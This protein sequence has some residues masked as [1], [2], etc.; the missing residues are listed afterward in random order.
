MPQ[1]VLDLFGSARARPR[2][3]KAY[4]SGTG[5][6]RSRRP[7]VLTT[8]VALRL[9]DAGV[10]GVELAWRWRRHQMTVLGGHRS[11]WGS[12]PPWAAA[13]I[14]SDPTEPLLIQDVPT[15]A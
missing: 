6:V 3:V 2:V 1:A 8:D 12:T 7:V 10:G 14:L 13:S 4:A 9:R 15:A 11:V 5:W